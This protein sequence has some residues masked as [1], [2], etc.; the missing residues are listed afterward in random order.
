MVPQNKLI[1]GSITK[2]L[3]SFTLPILFAICL[4]LLYGSVDMLIVG[5]FGSTADVSGVATGGQIMT[6]V[7]SV[8]TG[9]SMGATILIGQKIGASAHKEVGKVIVNAVILSATLAF[10]IVLI[11]MVLHQNILIWTNVPIDAFTQ[12]SE[13]LYYCTWG[14][15]IIFAYNVLGSVFR[16][17]GDSKTPLVAVG[18]AAI[19]N[20]IADLILVG[21]FGFG[22]KGAAIATVFAQLMS[23]VLCLWL[24]KRRPALSISISSNDIALDITYL[25]RLAT[26]GAPVALQ[27]SLCNLSFLAVTIIVN[28]FG[29]VFSAA[30]GITE[31]LIGL[32]M[33][34]P[35]AFM[36]SLAVFVAQNLG[37]NQKERAKKG[38][39]ISMGMSVG[40]A[41]IMVAVALIFGQEILGV[42]NQNP[43]VIVEAYSYL[44]VYTFDILL[45]SIHFCLAGYYSGCGKTIFVMAQGLIGAV[46]LRIPLTYFFSTIEPVSLFTIGISIPITSSVEIFLFIAYALFQKKR[47]KQGLVLS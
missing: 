42:F 35:M 45:V 15:P 8:C 23:V 25:M 11:L 44:K 19:V 29:V 7:T 6:L 37:A 36:Q 18:I 24:V 17:L 43:E 16:G 39:W 21:T 9:F 22:A 1:G 40:V 33:L 30:V 27:N 46:L 31:K 34:L 3:L 47:Q 13:Y 28:R 2:G 14:I 41:C 26:L 32:F 20:V 38:L 5:N 4:Q 12:T 10:V